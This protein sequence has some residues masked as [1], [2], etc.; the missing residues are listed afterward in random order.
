MRKTLE[1]FRDLI[2]YCR[3]CGNC[4]ANTQALR[5]PDT[6]IPPKPT[7]P[8][9][10]NL[11]WTPICPAYELRRFEA[12]N[13]GGRHEIVRDLFDGRLSIEDC[14]EVMYFCN[15]CG[16]CDEQCLIYVT[17]NIYR[18]T[19][20][21]R[22]FREYAVRAGIGPLPQ[23]K[24]VL[25]NIEKTGNIYGLSP[26]VLPDWL[27]V[28]EKEADLL[29]FIGC[30]TAYRRRE[31]AKAN[32]DIFKSLNI[33]VSTALPDEVCCGTPVLQIG[34]TNLARDLAE[35]NIKIFQKAL[36]DGI[37]KV[38]TSCP[39]CF[40]A[41]KKDVLEYFDLKVPMEVLHIT[42]FYA[43]LLDS[44]KMRFKKESE[45]LKV[46]YHDPCDLGRYSGIYEPPRKLLENIPG[47][48]FIEMNRNR[49]FAWCC[50]A[51]GGVKAAFPDAAVAIGIYRIREAEE[52]GAEV[53]AVS[54]PT[55]KDN[56][57]DSARKLGSKIKIMDISEILQSVL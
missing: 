35:K 24:K 57:Q 8:K 38:I 51:G 53:I 14:L 21:F 55:C 13:A 33:K 25:S 11:A 32:L 7:R 23:H 52:T 27:R 48:S 4:K 12:Y 16:S 9:D 34:D 18:P 39:G 56:L 22:A 10:V 46:T 50:G 37:N 28:T 30:T 2:R 6:D 20:V 42:E 29:Y 36:D 47:I 19:D 5:D 43:Q 31:I 40:R 45:R 41:L 44:G 17:A 3:H 54:C 49:N 26:Q 1:E 15:L